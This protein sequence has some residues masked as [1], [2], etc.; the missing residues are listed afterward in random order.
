M[1]IRR[2]F[3]IVENAGWIGFGLFLIVASGGAV[4]KRKARNFAKATT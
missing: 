3:E 2:A 1:T 4:L